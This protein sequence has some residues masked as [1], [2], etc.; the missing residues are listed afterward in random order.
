MDGTALQQKEKN[1]QKET[2]NTNSIILLFYFVCV[3]RKNEK[4]ECASHELPSASL[5][6]AR[7]VAHYDQLLQ[8]FTSSPQNFNLP[9]ALIT[10]L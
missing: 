10:G 3:N 1:R 6:K 9:T 8:E 2:F 5:G 7:A 4:N